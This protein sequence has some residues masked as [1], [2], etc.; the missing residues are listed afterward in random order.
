MFAVGDSHLIEQPLEM[1]R[2]TSG[3]TYIFSGL[4]GI[5]NLQRFGVH[6]PGEN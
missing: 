1:S 6:K 5:I 4:A 2:I 3:R